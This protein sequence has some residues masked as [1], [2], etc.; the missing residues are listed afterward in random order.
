MIIRSTASKDVAGL[1]RILE[2]TGLFPP[3]MLP[4]MIDGFLSEA[5]AG[6]LWLTSETDGEVCGF[7]YAV[8]E[9]MTEGT[10]N[11][12]A[13]A[14]LPSRQGNGAGGALVKHL[15]DH[16]RARGHRLLIVDTSGSA[17]FENTRR[18]Y[19]NNRYVEEARI[20]DYWAEGDD[21]IVFWKAL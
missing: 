15:E 19:R 5:D 1:K 3:E 20:R 12:L 21:K 2:G 11:M 7:C 18:F 8:P 9:P 13:I 4:D 6:D 17:A 14:V 16:L 10:W